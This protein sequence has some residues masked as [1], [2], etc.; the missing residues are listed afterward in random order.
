[1]ICIIGPIGWQQILVL[2]LE[3]PIPL[4]GPHLSGESC[5]DTRTRGGPN[6]SCCG[7]LWAHD[8]TFRVPEHLRI[9]GSNKCGRRGERSAGRADG[10]RADVRVSHALVNA[11]NVPPPPPPPLIRS[12]SDPRSLSL[13][14]KGVFPF[15]R[16]PP[17]L[18]P[19][20]L[21]I[22]PK[23]RTKPRLLFE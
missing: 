3:Q 22:Q 4:I 6:C 8:A 2:Y 13:M 15:S 16:R 17:P 19:A 7:C 5:G 20:H 1:M 9:Y 14:M 11:T 18:P 23:G 10:G 12:E 21:S